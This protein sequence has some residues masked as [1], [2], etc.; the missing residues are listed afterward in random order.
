MQA[1]NVTCFM[2]KL[3]T[4]NVKGQMIRGDACALFLSY[5]YYRNLEFQLHE[6]EF[7]CTDSIYKG[8]IFRCQT[9]Y[10]RDYI[11]WQNLPISNKGL[12]HIYLLKI[13]WNTRKGTH[14]PAYL[15][16]ILPYNL[17]VCIYLY[18]NPLRLTQIKT[19]A[20]FIESYS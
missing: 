10:L 2:T 5:Y 13:S 15:N 7:K 8:H 14:L 20:S 1:F 17:R 19:Y 12:F 18:R 6:L 16:S 9:F 4:E 3:R 11:C